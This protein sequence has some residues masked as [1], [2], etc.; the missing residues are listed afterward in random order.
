MTSDTKQQTM[1][2]FAYGTLRRGERLHAWLNGGIVEDLGV[3]YIP[4]ARL[5]FARGHRQFPYLRLN[6]TADDRAVGEVYRIAVDEQTIE[7]L[8]MEINAGYRVVETKAV[9]NGEDVF[10][11]VCICDEANAY[12]CGPEVPDNDWCSV[13]RREWWV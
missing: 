8:Q 12:I 11:T 1:L 10:V 6:G 7:M 9:V 4:K 5:F 13:A 3:G 2:F